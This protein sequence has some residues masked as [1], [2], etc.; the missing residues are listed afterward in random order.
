MLFTDEHIEQIINGNKTQ[1]RRRWEDKQVIIGNSYRACPSIF[2]ERVNSPA[3]IVVNDVY[4]EKL[5]DLSEEDASAEGNYTCQ[6]FKDVWIDM[7]GGWNEEEIIWVVDFEGYK[8]DPR[9]Q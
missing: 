4:T 5:G 8:K 9:I 1:T 2:T 6:E 7:H 3:Y